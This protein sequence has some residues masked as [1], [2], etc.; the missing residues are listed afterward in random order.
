MN[1]W[2]KLLL[3]VAGTLLALGGI[4]WLGLQIPPRTLP[5][6]VG[7]TQERGA[8]AVPAD[9]PAPVRRYLQVAFGDQIPR[10]ETMAA[11]GRARARFGLW[12]PLRY[13]LYHRPGV[14]FRR[15][16]EITWFGLP[17][18][19]AL[20]VY[21]HGEGATG[22]LNNLATGPRVNQG[23]NLILWAEASFF[24]SLLVTDPRIRW[25]P[26]DESSAR[27]I[28][29]FDDETDEIIFSFDPE[30]GL[31]ARTWALRYQG[32]SGEKVPWYAEI[33]SWQTV[34]GMQLPKRVAV[35]WENEGSP[36]SYWDFDAIRWNV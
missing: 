22:P 2:G 3:G 12:M 14:A 16:M 24:P 9:L 31:L 1:R 27:L 36:W 29:P 34:D 23:A 7:A 25:E 32:H 8:V 10:V 5:P 35:T 13:R 33:V 20:D 21:N 11:W 18:L 30:T 19:K 17:I 26:I 4:G 28:F 6:V 15:E